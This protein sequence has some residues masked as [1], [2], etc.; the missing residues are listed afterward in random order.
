[1]NHKF[2]TT[3]LSTLLILSLF[4]GTGC[5]KPDVIKIGILGDITGR[6]SYLGVS[7]R[8]AVVQAVEEFNK[9]SED[10]QI[11]LSIKDDKGSSEETLKCIDEFISE[12]VKLVIGPLTSNVALVIK[13]LPSETASNILFVSPT[14]S[15]NFM[16]DIDDNFITLVDSSDKQ[17]MMLAKGAI[18]LGLK[19]IATIYEYN[20]KSYSEPV[21]KAFEDVFKSLGGE[22]VYAK[23]FN[24]SEKAPFNELANEIIASQANG[25]LI[26]AGGLD[27][28]QLI[29]YLHKQKPDLPI[30]CGTWAKTTDFISNG[31]KAIEG[32]YFVGIM[33]EYANNAEFK[34][35]A[36]NYREL[37]D[38]EP[39]FAAMCGYESAKILIEAIQRG[40]SVEPQVVK[41]EIIKNNTFKGL[42]L[43]LYIDENGDSERPYTMFQVQESK[44]IKVRE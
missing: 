41:E 44:Y 20:N 17:G 39:T 26:I 6:S 30:Y 15:G 16:Y 28:S 43:D 7:N 23:H 3:L 10:F 22:V 36:E 19:K 37:Y 40:D 1:M 4:I 24:S 33:D 12:G 13:N 34:Q 11:Q 29:Q 35:F 14:V 42:N 31:G 25:V 32:T 38:F 18:E 21:V 2:I 5:T 9:S 8:N 27:S